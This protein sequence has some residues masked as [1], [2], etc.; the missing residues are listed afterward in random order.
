[1]TAGR[2]AF[3]VEEPLLTTSAGAPAWPLGRRASA[4]GP[5]LADLPELQPHP[6]SRLARTRRRRLC[7]SLQQVDGQTRYP[8]P[9]DPAEEEAAGPP[10]GSASS[11]FMCY[12]DTERPR[13]PRGG[14]PFQCQQ[15]VELNNL[16]EPSE[17]LANDGR[18]AGMQRVM[19]KRS[20]LAVAW[21]LA[22]SLRDGPRCPAQRQSKGDSLVRVWRD[23]L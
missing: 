8:V 18:S 23:F 17:L 2:L 21:L 6:A 16:S 15:L 3:E 7:S 14:Q 11:P 9:A 22:P 10:D 5:L 12:M 4:S 1:M 20:P 13:G 19:E